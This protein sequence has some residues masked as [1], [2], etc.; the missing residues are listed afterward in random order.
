M[1]ESHK[2]DNIKYLA[3]KASGGG[4]AKLHSVFASCPLTVFMK[5]LAQRNS[6]YFKQS[7]SISAALLAE[8]VFCHLQLYFAG[9]MPVCSFHSLYCSRV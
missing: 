2:L 7:Q 4:P 5:A 3:G 6:E 9:T 1:L 8:K